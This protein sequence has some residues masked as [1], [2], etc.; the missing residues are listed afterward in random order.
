M[1]RLARNNS[2]SNFYHVMV[3]G[4][5]KKYIFNTRENI[6]FYIDLIIKKIK[7][8][9]ITV[10]AYCIMNN[11]AHFLIFSEDY[12]DLSKF[13]QR[14][15]TTYSNYYNRTNKR[16]GYVFRDRYRSQDIMNIQQLYTCLRYIHNNPVKAKMCSSMDEYKYSSYNEFIGEKIIIDEKS[17]KILFGTN[18]DFIE[19]F[20]YIHKKSDQYN[21][22]VFIDIVDKDIIEF[23]SEYEQQN[24]ILV[25]ELKNNKNALKKFIKDAKNQTNVTLVELAKILNMSKSSVSIYYRK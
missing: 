6:K 20:K 14:I 7:E 24:K 21:D 9:N 25:A 2:K 10:L 18:K 17:I 3:Q 5:D 12:R 11:H 19:D 8:S 22:E 13:M 16:V 1:P 4:I 23:I 15:N